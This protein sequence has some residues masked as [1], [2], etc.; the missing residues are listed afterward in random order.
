MPEY[1]I[2]CSSKIG[3]CFGNRELVIIQEGKSFREEEGCISQLNKNAY[4]IEE[5]KEG[6]NLL[7]NLKDD[8]FSAEEVEV[9]QLTEETV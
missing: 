2:Y 7:T 8:E 1:A 6:C 5:D 3:P 4:R 9:W